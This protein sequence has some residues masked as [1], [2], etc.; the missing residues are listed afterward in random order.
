M[1]VSPA[2]GP[3]VLSSPRMKALMLCIMLLQPVILLQAS[4]YPCPQPPAP[5]DI[6]E[7]DPPGGPCGQE[8]QHHQCKSFM[9][10]L[11]MGTAPS[12]I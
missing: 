11:G 1:R 10:S 4:W 2:A 6:W 5:D 7:A 8:P 9:G 3:L 12:L